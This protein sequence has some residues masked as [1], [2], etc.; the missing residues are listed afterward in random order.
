MSASVPQKTVGNIRAT[1]RRGP[2]VE[3]R[4]QEGEVTKPVPTLFSTPKPSDLMALCFPS[5]SGGSNRIRP[6][7]RTPRG[8]VTTATSASIRWVFVSTRT[9]SGE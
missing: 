1:C 7:F 9:P 5:G 8:T 6:L 3:R 2:A 4:S